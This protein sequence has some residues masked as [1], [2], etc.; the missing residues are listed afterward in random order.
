MV[1]N[2]LHMA[3]HKVVLQ[4]GFFIGIILIRARKWHGSRRGRRVSDA[5]AWMTTSSATN[6]L[7]E[8][9]SRRN[10]STCA[11]TRGT[12][13]FSFASLCQLSER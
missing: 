5:P 8:C 4:H 6:Q 10:R 1:V 11:C 7:T 9:V 2:V 3:L 12:L 13:L